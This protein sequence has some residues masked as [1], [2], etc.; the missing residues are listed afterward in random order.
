MMPNSALFSDAFSSLRCACSAAK[1][2]RSAGEHMPIVGS[3]PE[4][5]L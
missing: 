5:I 3:A 1:R 2:G 4:R